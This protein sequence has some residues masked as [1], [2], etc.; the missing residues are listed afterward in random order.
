MGA[1]RARAAASR[2]TR[3]TSATRGAGPHLPGLATSDADGPGALPGRRR[4]SPRTGHC[5]RIDRVS[6]ERCARDVGAEQAI[7]PVAVTSIVFELPRS[8]ST[9]RAQRTAAG[10]KQVVTRSAWGP[11][12]VRTSLALA[13]TA[14]SSHASAPSGTVRTVDR[15]RRG[16]APSRLFADAGDATAVE[17]LRAHPR[18]VGGCRVRRRHAAPPSRPCPLHLRH[19]PRALRQL[20]M[21]P[22]R[23]LRARDGRVGGDRVPSGDRVARPIEQRLH[24][25]GDAQVD[26]DAPAAARPE[27]GPAWTPWARAQ[28][29]SAP[30]LGAVVVVLVLTTLHPDELWR[31]AHPDAPRRG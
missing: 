9:Q 26:H 31:C 30:R 13:S 25:V 1:P 11:A 29:W 5:G 22:Q 3:P 2:T 17:R 6:R 14:P 4:S 16:M 21:H 18:S 10:C 7:V 15:R 28:L 12:V 24:V 8:R 23:G 19:E 27:E 20:R